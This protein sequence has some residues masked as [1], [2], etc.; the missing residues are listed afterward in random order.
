MVYHLRSTLVVRGPVAAVTAAE[1]PRP[2][3]DIAELASKFVE[4]A[5][6]ISVVAFFNYFL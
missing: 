1:S 3:F 5:T 2:E 4:R 6:P